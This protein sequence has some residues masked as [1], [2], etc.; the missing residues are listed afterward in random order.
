M[1]VTARR[2]TRWR[3]LEVAKRAAPGRFVSRKMRPVDVARTRRPPLPEEVSTN[4]CSAASSQTGSL[5]HE[6]RTRP[7]CPG[8]SARW[9]RATRSSPG[10]DSRPY[11]QA[12]HRHPTYQVSAA[13][14]APLWSTSF[15]RQPAD[16]ADGTGPVRSSRRPTGRRS[17]WRRPRSP[18]RG[19]SATS[20]NLP[21]AFFLKGAL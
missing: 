16:V 17:R 11:R 7:W 18:P 9:P 8:T 6:V 3:H 12:A 20:R 1:I 10:R 4:P 14:A 21:P 19:Q 15:V 13:A 5:G 2:P